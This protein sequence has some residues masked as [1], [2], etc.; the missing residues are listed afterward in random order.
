VLGSARAWELRIP[1]RKCGTAPSLAPSL[2]K[3]LALT[4][5]VPPAW[6]LTRR[7]AV[8]ALVPRRARPTAGPGLQILK[9]AKDREQIRSTQSG[10]SLID[11]AD[12]VLALRVPLEE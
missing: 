6:A 11:L 5:D 10:A 8:I 3:P 7:C 1:I 2:G 9:A 4:A 12:G